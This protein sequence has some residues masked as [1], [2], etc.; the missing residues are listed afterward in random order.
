M[1]QW[2]GVLRMLGNERLVMGCV[3]GYLFPDDDLTR[4][5]YVGVL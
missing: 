1:E 4:S 3:E 2:L 5:K